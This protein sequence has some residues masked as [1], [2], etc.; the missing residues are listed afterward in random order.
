MFSRLICTDTELKPTTDNLLSNN[1]VVQMSSGNPKAGICEDGNYA[2]KDFQGWKNYEF[3]V[4]APA[5]AN[6]LQ[7]NVAWA[8]DAYRQPLR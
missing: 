6:T 5:D 2:F 8:A 7:F 4:K 3:M 1:I